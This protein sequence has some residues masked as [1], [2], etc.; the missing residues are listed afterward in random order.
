M[1]EGGALLLNIIIRVWTAVRKLGE[2]L[3]LSLED[4][5]SQMHVLS[6]PDGDIIIDR[7]AQLIVGGPVAVDKS[8]PADW[9]DILLDMLIQLGQF[10]S[11]VNSNING[12]NFPYQPG[13]LDFKEVFNISIKKKLREL[14]RDWLSTQEVKDFLAEQGYRPATLVELLWWWLQ[15]PAKHKNCLVVALGSIWDDRVPC[16][17]GDDADRGLGLYSVQLHWDEGYVFAA[18][19]K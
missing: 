18:V 3:E 15:N 17:S 16:V 5:T 8:A 13:D 19:R 12:T 6:T 4:T 1:V 10:V 7:I 2:Q 14:G 11:Y 9:W